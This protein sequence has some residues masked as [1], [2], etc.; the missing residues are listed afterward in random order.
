MTEQLERGAAG[1]AGPATP[2]ESVLD[3][4]PWES[5]A[6]HHARFALRHGHAVRY[7]RDVAPFVALEDF[8]DPQAWRDVVELL[9]PGE[10]LALPGVTEW[11]DDWRVV[12]SAE[13]VQMVA[14]RLEPWP[15]PEAVRLGANDVPEMLD[16]VARTEPGPFLP[17]TVELGT[18]LGIRRE[19]ALVAMAGERLHPPGWTEIS[20]VCTDAAFRGQGLASRLVRAVAAGIVARGETPFLHAIGTNANAIRLYE[21]MGFELRRTTAITVLEQA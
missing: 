16:L 14:R 1:A 8:R 4:A 3:R 17:R 15:D 12:R 20:A 10:K 19:G 11:P 2:A 21:S 5:L 13:G 7:Q 6:G 9:E 18:Y